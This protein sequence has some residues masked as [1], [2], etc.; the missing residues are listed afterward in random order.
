MIPLASLWLRCHPSVYAAKSFIERRR[1]HFPMTRLWTIC[2]SVFVYANQTYHYRYSSKLFS[3]NF[4]LVRDGKESLPSII[5]GVCANA[6]K[7]I[8]R[9]AIRKSW[10]RDVAVYYLVAGNWNGISEEFVKQGDM[11]WVD[12]PEDYRNALTPKTL[13]FLHFGSQ[14]AMTK[15]SADYIFKTDEDVF[16]NATKMSRELMVNDLPDYYGLL[17]NDTA[18]IRNVTNHGITSKW[19]ISVEEYP[20]DIFP[21]YAHGT[22]YAISKKFAICHW[23]R[24]VWNLKNHPTD[25]TTTEVNWPEEATYRG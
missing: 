6:A 7:P 14:V 17:R 19:Y 24:F 18:P 1:N 8:R 22:G 5:F 13:A 9:Q 20:E 15:L 3:K 10:G 12:I 21:P 4:P 25:H 2:L 11:L 16:I 23:R